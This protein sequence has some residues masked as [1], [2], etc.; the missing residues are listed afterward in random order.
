MASDK[1]VE[2]V[3]GLDVATKAILMYSENHPRSQQAVEQAFTLLTQELEARGALN[4]SIAEGNLLIEG[5]SVEKGNPLIERF[6]RDILARNIHSLSF[7]RGVTRPEL[8]SF[9]R[10]LNLKPQRIKDLGGFDKVLES[11]GIKNVQANKVKYG[12]ITE[13]DAAQATSEQVLLS[14]LLLSMQAGG[15]SGTIAENV[16]KSVAASGTPDA[17]SS[18]FRVFQMLAQSLPTTEAEQQAAPPVKERFLQM[19]RSF[20]PDLQGKLLLNAVL[21]GASMDGSALGGFHRDLSPEELESSI[22]ALLQ[23][24]G[25]QQ[26]MRTF[27]DNLEKEKGIVLTDTVRKKFGEKGLGKPAAPPNPW[28]ELLAKETLPVEE[29]DLLPETLALMLQQNAGAEADRLSK[30]VFGLLGTGTPE[31]RASIIKVIPAAIGVLSQHEKWKN[32]EF[33]FGFLINNYYRKETSPMVI[34]GYLSYFLNAFGKNFETGKFRECADQ[35]SLIKSKAVTL[36]ALSGQLSVPLAALPPS[37]ADA[38]KQSKDGSE[39]ALGLVNACANGGAGYVL[40]LLADEE[41]QRVRKRLIDLTESF[42]IGQLLPEIERRLSDPRWFVARNMVTILSKMS[43]SESTRLLQKTAMH[44]DVRV[45]KEIVKKLYNAAAP[46]D[47]PIVVQLLQHP[48]KS[49]RLQAIHVALMMQAFSAVPEL[50]H[51]LTDKNPME[52]DQR[53]AA[54]QALLKI[55]PEEAVQPAIALLERK[56]AGKAETAERNA[57]VRALGEYDRQKFRSLL[58]KL[59]TGDPNPETRQLAHSYL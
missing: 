40:D 32:I 7:L 45:V 21:K 30:K 9:L 58:E 6:T 27:V 35:L 10:Q 53:T 56:P 20:T 48:D 47:E 1:L 28:E 36:E 57:A 2:T 34:F 8:V 24:S 46:T 3:K 51:I 39:I 26:E 15:G 22:L 4:V 16:E 5:E 55:K 59:A 19:Y 49:L 13:G 25:N 17:A 52:T 31:Q 50:V 41:D 29:I 18:I 54:Y 23:Q 38:V 37:F 44:S 11:E 43:S 12:I 33:S 42:D 14:Q